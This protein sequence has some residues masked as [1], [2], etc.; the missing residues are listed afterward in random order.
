MT[1]LVVALLLAL[2]A[3]AGAT[4]YGAGV[5]DAFANQ[6]QGVWSAQQTVA[7]LQ[8]LYAAGG[9]LGRT[10]VSW[11]SSEPAAPTRGRHVYR[12]ATADFIAGEMAQARVRWQPILADPPMWAQQRGPNQVPD[13]NGVP[14]TVPL[15]PAHNAQF[16]AFAAAFARRYG[17]GGSFWRSHSSLPYVPVRAFEV[18][19]EPDEALS[20]GP[21]VN[22]QHYA[23]M[24]ELVR[25]AIRR[26]DRHAQVVSGGLAWTPTSLPRLLKAFRGKPL[27][28]IAFHPYA[29]TPQGTVALARYAI[30]QLAKYG[31]G[32][33][34]LF[35]NEFGWTSLPGIWGST[36]PAN[37]DSYV[38]QA[39][40]G[41]SKLHL[42]EVLPFQWAMPSW[43]LSDGT[44]AR[45]L[46][47]IH[48]G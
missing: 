9:Q 16:A 31:R 44:F 46:T 21:D 37:L 5:G 17:A 24:Y 8:A 43:G 23:V 47:A 3:T 34:P 10:E 30:K 12:W 41:L 32:R 1:V 33:T 28:A 45:A 36:D 25:S 2:P 35:A 27:D 39:L 18:W 11:A 15:P 14:V 48:D 40:L 38:Y 22:L 6:T 13:S 20:W 19:N 7:S 42:T 4:S 29:A 26:V